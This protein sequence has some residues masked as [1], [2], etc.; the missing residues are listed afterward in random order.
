M[1][2]LIVIPARGG[3]KGIPYK[4]I[5]PVADKPLLAWTLDSVTQVDF[6]GDI[7]VSTDDKKIAEVAE[8]YNKVIVIKRPSELSGDRASTES[9][10][11]HALDYMRENGGKKYD[12]VVTMQPTSPLRTSKLIENMFKTYEE[13]LG[14]YNALLTLT[15]DRTDF[16]IQK[17]DNSF[18]RLFK[19]APRRRQERQPL[20]AE[21]SALYITDAEVLRETNSV[22]GTKTLGYVIDP[23]E[24]IDI[25]EKHDIYVAESFLRER[26]KNE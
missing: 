13:N 12:A 24:A 8:R 26:S 7:V 20:F 22:L 19:D 3:S 17:P 21:N 6:C 16:W 14:R 11:I 9:A 23:I 2:Y 15:E 18:E 4:N 1:K 10:L 25:N 5:Y